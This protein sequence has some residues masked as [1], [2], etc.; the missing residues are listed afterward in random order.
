LKRPHHSRS[1]LTPSEILE[2]PSPSQEIEPPL[3]L[4]RLA[5]RLLE[6]SG[7][8]ADLQCRVARLEAR[9]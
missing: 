2:P 3:T 9:R 4:K 6:L 8:V 7:E 5:R 1:H